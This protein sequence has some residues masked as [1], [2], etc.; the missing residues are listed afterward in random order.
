[1][2]R[3]TGPATRKSRRLGVDLVGGDQSFEKRPYP[4]GQHGR[5]RIKESE[6]R[7]Q[8]QEKQKAR[9][10]YGVMEK[11]FR[12][13]YDEAVR[14]PGKT[15]DN[16]LRILESRLDNVVY[17]AGLARTR[18][19]ARQLVSH[20]HFLVNGKKVNIPSY[21]VEQYDIID[22]RDKSLNMLPF[23]IARET[24]GDRPVPSWLQVVGE[25]PRILVH[26]LP[27]RDQIDVPLTEQLIVELYSK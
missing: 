2:A 12:R 17:R 14:Q 11:Q 6:Y 5:A 4:P 10:T 13:Y 1:M 8:L 16:L 27:T 23:Q 25:R 24:M 9:F 20:G 18:R 7:L 26:Q 19:M 21:R 3:Y 22:I 15:G